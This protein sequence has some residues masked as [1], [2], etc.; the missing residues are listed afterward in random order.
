MRKARGV[1]ASALARVAPL[2]LAGAARFR[3]ELR[4]GDLVLLKGRGTDH[5]ARLFFAQFGPLACW[6]HP[7]HFQ[8]ICDICP[9]LGARPETGDPFAGIRA[10][11]AQ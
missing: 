11:G 6:K 4:A 7:C 3:R 5:L 1:R 8:I 9:Q 10:F 2:K